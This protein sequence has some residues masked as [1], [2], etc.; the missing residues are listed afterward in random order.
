MI[1]K[2]KVR[3]EGHAETEIEFS[4]GLSVLFGANDGGKSALNRAINWTANN[5]PRGDSMVPWLGKQEAYSTITK[6]GIEITRTKSG[7]RNGYSVGPD[8]YDVVGS[9]VP[10]EVSQALNLGEINIQRQVD[11]YY[12]LQATAG[13]VAKLINE[14]AGIQE[15]D[16]AIKRTKELISDSEKDVK[17]Q[18]LAIKTQKEYL[19]SHSG[20]IDEAEVLLGTISEMCE[21]ISADEAAVTEAEGVAQGLRDSAARLA[22]FPD[23]EKALGQIGDI[24][25][26]ERTVGEQADYCRSAS[27]LCSQLL[28]LD[29]ERFS[30]L[31]ECDLGGLEETAREVSQLEKDLGPA[32]EL[33]RRLRELDLERFSGL[34]EAAGELY[35]MESLIPD[36]WGKEQWLGRADEILTKLKGI[37]QERFCVLDEADPEP[38]AVLAEEIR[39]G[40]EKLKLLMDVWVL[41]VRVSTLTEQIE[42]YEAEVAKIPV[43][44]TC[45]RALEV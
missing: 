22:A 20:L 6:D 10:E 26:L 34:D 19:D 29:L 7:K 25:E 4:P 40:S 23:Y 27:D 37:D 5:S 24:Y 43:C 44:P 38:L 33:L 35:V 15:S 45:N 39:K 16:K 31:G 11:Q 30:V 28:L 2:I 9:S 13:E 14:I 17:V 12:L 1:E 21:D 32:E 36:I 3:Y 42:E 18:K 41:D 8:S